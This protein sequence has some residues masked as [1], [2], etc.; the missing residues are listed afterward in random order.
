MWLYGFAVG[1]VLTLGIQA[2]IRHERDLVEEFNFGGDAMDWA[3]T[4]EGRLAEKPVT[5][6]A[7]HHWL[8]EISPNDEEVRA[9]WKLP[10]FREG[11]M[12]ML[13]RHQV[14]QLCQ[15]ARDGAKHNQ[16]NEE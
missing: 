15:I 14:A 16:T 12:F 2:L 5:Q 3:T 6:E 13:S 1:I 11:Y 4:L 8:W 7:Y 10:A 9:A